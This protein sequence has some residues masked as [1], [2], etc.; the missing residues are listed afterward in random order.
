EP[1]GTTFAWTIDCGTITNPTSANPH[2]ACFITPGVCRI[3]VI[4]SRPGEAPDTCTW[5]T[6]VFPNSFV[7]IPEI[8]CEG[9]SVE[10]NGTYYTAGIYMDTIFGGNVHGCDSIL[11]IIVAEIPPMFDTIS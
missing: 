11:T 6:I 4:V 3:D 5:F 10:V 8:I 9:D 7:S 2:T 1:P